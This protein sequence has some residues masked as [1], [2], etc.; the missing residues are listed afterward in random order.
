MTRSLGLAGLGALAGASLFAGSANATTETVIAAGPS[1]SDNV[2]LFVA[3]GAVAL[4]SFALVT[5]N[6]LTAQ[7][8]K[9]RVRSRRDQ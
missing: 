8:A 4:A 6:G 1:V 5:W 3:A 9:V 7:K 2:A